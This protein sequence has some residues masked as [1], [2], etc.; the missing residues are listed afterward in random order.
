MKRELR[1]VKGGADLGSERDPLAAQ[2]ADLVRGAAGQGAL[3]TGDHEA[4]LALALGDEAASFDAAEC[5]AAAALR[6][7][8]DGAGEHP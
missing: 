2:V 5:A 6:D 8:L 3:D 4:L 7:A 1:L